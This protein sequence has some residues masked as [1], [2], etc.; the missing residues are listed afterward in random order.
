M[1][2]RFANPSHQTD[3]ITIPAGTRIVGEAWSNLMGSGDK[4]SDPTNPTVMVK[5]GEPGSSGVLEITD[6]VF[7][8]RGPGILLA[9]GVLPFH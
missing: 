1:L 9:F 2:T 6:M 3:T 8:T 5:V 4:F 7:K